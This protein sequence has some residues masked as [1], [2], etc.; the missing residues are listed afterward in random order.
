MCITQTYVTRRRGCLSSRVSSADIAGS[1]GQWRA[2]D[3]RAVREVLPK[4]A[5]ALQ[6]PGGGAEGGEPS[7][8]PAVVLVALLEF[9]VGN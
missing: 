6:A 7:Y 4:L 2:R 8:Q 9:N 3:G 5:S 1:D